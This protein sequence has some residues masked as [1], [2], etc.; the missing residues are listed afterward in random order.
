VR[1][2]DIRAA[3]AECYGE[4]MSG[5]TLAALLLGIS[6][7][8][9]ACGH[10]SSAVLPATAPPGPTSAPLGAGMTLQNGKIVL[11]AGVS[12]STTKLTV[13]NSVTSAAP[14]ADGTFSLAAFSGGPQFTVVSSPAGTP[15]LTGFLGPSATTIDSATTAQ[16]LIYFAAGLY[17]LPSTYRTQAVTAVANAPGFAQVQSAIESAL[18]S[19]PDAFAHGHTAGVTSA[20]QTFVT[21]LYG[22]PAGGSARRRSPREVQITPGTAQ[23]GI[24]VLNDF[25]NGIHFSN[26]FRRGAV[27]FVDRESYV[28]AS[29]NAQPAAITDYVKPTT[30]PP[31]SG[32]STVSGSLLSAVQGYYSGAT[33]YTPT[34]TATIPLDVIP[35]SR[36]TRYRVTVVGAGPILP[37]SIVLT[38]EQQAAQHLIVVQSLILDVLVPIVAS[39][40]IPMN[41]TAIDNAFNYTGG[42]AA[43]TDFIT[44]LATAQ[45]IYTLANDGNVSDAAVLAWNTIIG[46]N[47]LQLAFL[48]AVLSVLEEQYP[49]AA[50]QAAFAKGSSLL[51][52]LNVMSAVFVTSDL[53]VI[54]TETTN[55]DTANVTEVAAALDPVSLTPASSSVANSGTVGFTVSAPTASGSGETLVYTWSN[56]AKAGHITDGING[57]LDNFDSTSNKVTYTADSVGT[58]TDTITATVYAVQGSARTQIGKTVSA[59]VTVTAA[60]APLDCTFGDGTSLFGYSE[61]GNTTSACGFTFML[62][63]TPP[64]TGSFNPALNFG[65][66]GPGSEAPPITLPGG[67]TPLFEFTVGGNIANP[68]DQAVSLPF[69]LSVHMPAGIPSAGQFIYAVQC[70][71]V[72]SCGGAGSAVGL[73]ADGAYTVTGTAV[74]DPPPNNFYGDYYLVILYASGVKPS[75]VRRQTPASP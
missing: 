16:V 27:A 1:F 7:S 64:A 6:L 31:V 59:T 65:D 35:G 13:A 71:L 10:R 5:R 69:T 73:G 41:S 42:N 55:S 36:S 4:L 39:L 21:T 33:A 40:I 43:L 8:M 46:S 20:L 30:I 29:G 47:T 9:Q 32:L 15:M 26:A 2:S 75:A 60:E 70:E 18:Q 44:T 24:T 25:P 34:T 50:A 72:T 19:D 3:R 63:G 38:Q 58:G 45:Q 54:A 23:S 67:A 48:Q 68:S 22:S 49:A 37:S 61:P 12:V 51:N 11:P 56:S 14:N 62:T 28:D 74:A 53:L 17:M 52:V 57:H 66:F